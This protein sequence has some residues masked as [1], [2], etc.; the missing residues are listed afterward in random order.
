M[1]R[2]SST[3]FTRRGSSARGGVIAPPSALRWRASTTPRRWPSICVRVGNLFPGSDSVRF[4]DLSQADALA[5][6]RTQL[7]DAEGKT[8]ERER[9][10]GSMLALLCSPEKKARQYSAAKSKSSHKVSS[11]AQTGCAERLTW[12]SLRDRPAGPPRVRDQHSY[13][14]GTGGRHRVHSSAVHPTHARRAHIL[15]LTPNTQPRFGFRRRALR[16]T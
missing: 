3:G 16:H 10:L 12:R 7:D 13:G 6:L 5:W 14:S 11:R 8:P 9:R 15:I 4:P 1:P 2:R